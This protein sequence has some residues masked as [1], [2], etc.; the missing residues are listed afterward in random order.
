[1]LI[2][3][4]FVMLMIAFLIFSLEKKETYVAQSAL[5][6]K[7][8]PSFIAED[9]L[10]QHKQLTEVIFQ[11]ESGDF[12]LL[13]VWASWCFFCKKEHDFLQTLKQKNNIAIIGL[14]YRDNR[15]NAINY[16]TKSGNPYHSIIFDHNGSL[17][18]D[19]GVVGT[20]ETYLINHQG[21][22]LFRYTGPLNEGIWQS[23]FE[24]L[25]NEL[26]KGKEKKND[27]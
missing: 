21:I 9:L 19:L 3:A 10:D 16:L 14:D 15:S 27:Q 4:I 22:I 18:L 20:P 12:T 23:A 13:N 26:A 5:Q 17:A 11:K 1:M 24:P 6:G 25:I 7:P 8:I 2:P